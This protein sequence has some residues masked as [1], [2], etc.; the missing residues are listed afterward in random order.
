MKN[1]VKLSIFA[2]ALGFFA[3]C[4]DAATE[5]PATTPVDSTTTTATTTEGPATTPVDSTTTTA[6]TTEAPA[7]TTKK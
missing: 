3:S 7:D 2:I 4:S 6:T 5:G 1:L